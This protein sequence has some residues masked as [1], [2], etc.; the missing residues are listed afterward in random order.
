MDAQPRDADKRGFLRRHLA[1]TSLCAILLLLVGTAGSFLWYLNH[2]LANIRHFDAGI[3]EIPGP[4]GSASDAGRPLNILI[5]GSHDTSD[6]ESVPDDL[7]DGSWTPG[8]HNCDTIIVVHLPPNRQSAQVVSIPRDSWV[9]VPDYPGDVGGYAKINAS[10]SWGGP[11]LTVRTVQAFTGL[12]LDH[13][14]MIDWNGFQGLTD[15][16]GGV[17]VYVPQTFTDDVQGVTWVKGW[18][19]LSGSRALQYVRTRHGLAGGDFG[20]IERQQNFLRAVLSSVASSGTFTNPLRLARVIGTFADF[21]QVDNTWSTGDLRTLGL[22][23]RNLSS[24]NVSFTTA[25]F[26]R[27]DDIAGQS[28]VRLD[29]AKSATLFRE[30]DRG[31]ITPYLRANP[32]SALPGDTAVR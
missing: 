29:R 5:L 30:L 1:L 13:V 4:G 23:M 3:T 7:A 8:V 20:R 19:T 25:P 21:I 6:Q 9:K 28:V 12:H 14:A 15:V 2:E 22:A 18:Q 32:G 16:L 26:A 31:D 10:F 27:Y 11:A 24:A 17:R